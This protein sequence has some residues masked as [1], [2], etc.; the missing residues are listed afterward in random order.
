MP[1]GKGFRTIAEFS[2][3]T[4]LGRGLDALLP[5]ADVQPDDDVTTFQQVQGTLEFRQFKARGLV[6]VWLPALG[7]RPVSTRVTVTVDGVDHVLPLSSDV[8]TVN[9]EIRG[10]HIDLAW[11]VRPA[12]ERR[13]RGRRGVNRATTRR[14]KGRSR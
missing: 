9:L 2:K 11:R 7:R 10:S 4:A 13:S 5:P 6:S 3:R 8:E 14:T 12:R 1:K